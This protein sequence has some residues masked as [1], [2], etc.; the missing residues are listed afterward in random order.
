MQQWSS[1]GMSVGL[2]HGLEVEEGSQGG[3][4]AAPPSQT[5]RETWQPASWAQLGGW[6]QRHS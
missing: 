5:W 3:H 2:S 4:R 6:L 1:W